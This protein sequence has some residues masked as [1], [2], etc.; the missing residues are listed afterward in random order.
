MRN[1]AN[2]GF[3]PWLPS[4]ASF[5]NFL[6]CFPPCF[7]YSLRFERGP[8]EV[9]TRSERGPILSWLA[10]CPRQ[11]LEPSTLTG[12]GLNLPLYIAALRAERLS[13]IK[14]A[15]SPRGHAARLKSHYTGRSHITQWHSA[16]VWCMFCAEV[17]KMLC[18]VEDFGI[19]NDVQ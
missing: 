11:G 3:L 1:I 9:Q 12:Q 16:H 7:C 14:R 18:T 6:P 4:L 15:K 13:H 19:S 8:N 2:I 5:L 17:A 10:K